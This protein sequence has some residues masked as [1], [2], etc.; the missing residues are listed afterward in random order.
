MR[1]MGSRRSLTIV[2][3]VAAL[4]CAP[5]SP[6]LATAADDADM[7]ADLATVEG[8]LLDPKGR[9]AKG[10]NA[11]LRNVETGEEFFSP[12]TDENGEYA[13]RVPAGRSYVIVAAI[14]P[15]GDR[16]P[17]VGGEPI[18]VPVS[19]SYRVP[20][21]RFQP[22]DRGAGAV[23]SAGRPWYKTPGGLVGLVTGSVAVLIFAFDDDDDDEDA[24][25]SSP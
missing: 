24:S 6:L 23:P 15:S 4:L 14:T 10:L 20:D 18:P 16:L 7:G 17:V 13:L 11:V 12:A 19:G 1:S 25:P 22:R 21:V 9:P 2:P 3:I 5:L 8:L